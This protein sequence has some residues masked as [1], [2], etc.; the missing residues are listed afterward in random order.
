MADRQVSEA[1]LQKYKQWALI[2][3]RKMLRGNRITD[4]IKRWATGELGAEYR[5][6]IEFAFNEEAA[7]FVNDPRNSE[8][9]GAERIDE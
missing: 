9:L 4:Q 7:N 6:Q 5:F 8:V 3:F 1:E 2:Q